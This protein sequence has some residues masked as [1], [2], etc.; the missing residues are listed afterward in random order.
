MTNQLLT[1]DRV[2]HALG[3]PTRQTIVERLIQGP[4]SISELAR[5]L[6]MALPTVLKH[7]G[8]LEESGLVRSGTV[9]RTRTC[10]I[11]PAALTAAEQWLQD[12]RTV[13]EARFDRL[14][15][16]LQDLQRRTPKS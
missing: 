15:E 13:W 12:Q 10:H 4:A 9:G 3:S 7:V 14:D 6:A 2:F 16:Y 11:E 8:V 1:L 5:P